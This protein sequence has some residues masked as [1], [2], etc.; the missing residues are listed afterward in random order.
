[1]EQTGAQIQTSE[2]SAIPRFRRI[3]V[4]ALLI[5]LGQLAAIVWGLIRISL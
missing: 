5:N 3:H 4:A 2:L 1:M